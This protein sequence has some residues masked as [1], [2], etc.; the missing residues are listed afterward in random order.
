MEIARNTNSKRE[1]NTRRILDDSK[2]EEET[3]ISSCVEELVSFR[4]IIQVL[5]DSIDSML[6]CFGT[7][8]VTVSELCVRI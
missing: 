7:K 6:R 1:R 5:P 3:M 4:D 2:E 8:I